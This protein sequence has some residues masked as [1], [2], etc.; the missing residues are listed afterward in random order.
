MKNSGVSGESAAEQLE[1]LQTEEELLNLDSAQC[2]GG[3]VAA[4]AQH[5]RLLNF[6]QAV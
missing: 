4:G 5:L 1:C 6:R 2:A 3:L